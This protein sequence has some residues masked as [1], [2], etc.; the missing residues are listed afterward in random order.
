MLLFIS[1]VAAWAGDILLLKNDSTYFFLLA[2][3]AFSVTHIFLVIIFYRIHKLKLSKAPEAFIGT[4]ILG[5]ICFEFYKFISPELGSFKLPI[6]GYMV[7]IC[8]MCIMAI[9]LLGS[10]LRRQSAI[11]YFIPG[12]A[13]FILSDMVLASHKFVFKDLDFLPVIV[14]LSYGYAISL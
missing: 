4:L 9:N 3:L 11:N 14:I 8:V 10:S 2:M 13:L 5:A 1:F 6:I 12:A 7:I